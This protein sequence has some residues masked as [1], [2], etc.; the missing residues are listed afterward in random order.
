M[1]QPWPPPPSIGRTGACSANVSLDG[2]LQVM[3][4]KRSYTDFY[5]IM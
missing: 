3:R 5:H 4:A 2:F 1:S